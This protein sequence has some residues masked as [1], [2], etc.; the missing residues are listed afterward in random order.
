MKKIIIFLILVLILSM[1]SCAFVGD[2]NEQSL[3]E[4]KADT[5]KSL[6]DNI[7]SF[8]NMSYTFGGEKYSSY[9]FKD[10]RSLPFSELTV[11]DGDQ[12]IGFGSIV[13]SYY[14]SD[15]QTDTTKDERN[16][17]F[18]LHEL[19]ALP[20]YDIPCEHIGIL[21]EENLYV[22]LKVSKE[23]QELYYY[24]EYRLH[25]D[26]WHPHF[27]KNVNVWLS[28]GY[29]VFSTTEELEAHI[30]ARREYLTNKT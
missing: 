12:N 6:N 20:F 24:L 8:T 13:S 19:C 23:E 25:R 30:E 28:N 16:I 11:V 1:C 29:D 26:F 14:S 2:G 22:V 9:Y 10:W 7:F 21:D 3:D 18:C 27:D 4:T 5:Q 15:L 17:T